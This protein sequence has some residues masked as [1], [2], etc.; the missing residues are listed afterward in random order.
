MGQGMFGGATPYENQSLK[1]IQ[2]DIKKW[3]S[4][5]NEINGLFNVTLKELE[6]RNYK[7]YIPFNILAL[8][9][10]TIRTTV[11]FSHDFKV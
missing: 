1:E 7:Q 3:E 4:Y 11:T 2:D 5:S 9:L 10:D 8:F 6:D